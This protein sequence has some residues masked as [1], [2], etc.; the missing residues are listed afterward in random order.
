MRCAAQTYIEPVFDWTDVPNLHINKIEVTKDTTFVYCTYTAEAGS[1][2]NISQDTYLYDSV[3]KD[4]HPLLQ[5]LG[6]PISPQE[7]EFPYDSTYQVLFCFSSIG[8]ATKL[9]FIENLDEEAFNI[10]G[11]NLT[12]TFDTSYNEIDPE[13]NSEMSLSFDAAGD[14]INA[15]QY[16]EKE[17]KATAFIYGIKSKQFLMVVYDLCNMYEKYGYYEQAND[18]KKKIT[19]YIEALDDN[20]EKWHLL[21]CISSVFLQSKDLE[22][23]LEYRTMAV[24]IARRNWGNEHPKYATSLHELSINYYLIGNYAE[25][26]RLSTEAMEIRKNVLGAEHLNYV[27]SLN[28][29]AVYYAHLGKYEEAIRLGTEVL[30]ITRRG[31]CLEH[32]DYATALNNL[33]GYY[34]DFGNYEEAIRLGTEAM[35]ITK[36][37]LGPNHPDYAKA[38]YNLARFYLNIGNSEEAMRLGTET[39]EITKRVLGPDHPDYAK[40]LNTLA[41]CYSFVGNYFDAIRLGTEA[42]EITKKVLGTEHPE[43]ATLSLNLAGYYSDI[44]NYSKAIQLSTEALE[45]IKKVL[46]PDHPNYAT[47]LNNLASYYY[48]LRNYNTEAIRFGT[49]T[50]GIRKKVLDPDHPDYTQAIN[51]GMSKDFGW[52]KW[53]F[54]TIE[55]KYECIILTGYFVTS[56]NGPHEISNMDET[57]KILEKEYRIIYTSL[58]IDSLY[59]AQVHEWRAE[60]WYNHDPLITNE[61]ETSA[62][63]SQ[64]LLLKAI[65][66]HYFSKGDIANA[67]KFNPQNPY[68]H[69]ALGN[70]ETLLS[71]C[72]KAYEKSIDGLKSLIKDPVIITPGAYYN[73][74][75]DILYTS[76]L[77]TKIPYFAY[78]TNSVDLC[79]MAYNGALI[80]KNFRLLSDNRLRQYLKTTQNAISI[81][82]DTRIEKEKH[83]YKSMIQTKDLRSIDKGW[84][85]R[86]LQRGLIA[87][88]DSIGALNT[89][90][91]KW[92][93]VRSA[94]KENDIAVEFIEFPLWN[95][96]QSMYA[97]LTLRKESEHPKIIGLFEK[98]Q[99]MLISDTLYYQC[100]GMTDLVWKPLQSE[101]QGIKNIYF[102]PSGVLHKIGIEYLPGMENYNIFR[103]SS[104]RELVT[105]HEKRK[106]N[107]AVLYG[108]LEYDAK[109]DSTSTAKSLAL[110][111]ETFKMRGMGL[112][113]G[114]EY[115]ER[116][117]VEVV[118]IGEY[119]KDAKWTCLLDT[120]ALGTEE[121]FKSL[122]G[123][124]ISNLH[125]AT[126][127]FY[128][129]FDEVTNTN[130]D[131]L[132]EDTY[133]I[134]EEDKALKRSG[135]L[136]S[137]ANHILEGNS[138][139]Y[140]VEDGILTA[141]EIADVDLR[142]LDLVVLSACQTGLGDI[143]QGEGVFGLQRG[144][145]KAGA[146]TILMSLWEVDDKATQILMTQF[147]KNYLSGQSKHEA[148]LSAQK[149]L[150]EYNNGYYNKPRYWAAFI[151]LDG[152]E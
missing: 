102:S 55:F 145:K 72:K 92:T 65:E 1:R 37:V 74:E 130:Y 103:L 90:F 123:K 112:R 6:L 66:N 114:K 27:N 26:I 5:C 69:C 106:D 56:E 108:G 115:L 14:T 67:I 150:R 124:G 151:M 64:T 104:T 24:E 109:M 49:E 116:T 127:G 97:A 17:K 59:D 2:A 137:G 47:A 52:A 19:D 95:Q 152:L 28:D 16:K 9:D 53:F 57:I 48:H 111:D 105:K 75:F 11:I 101:L 85:I 125:I 62:L 12:S 35:E 36:K 70:T 143:S 32:P 29:I 100:G 50:T 30:K 77:T 147:Y 129:T 131:F 120:A 73:A 98:N 142:G 84:E 58:P 99:L 18:E 3:K 149:Y 63:F 13:Y 10:Y 94:L 21:S 22:K 132:Q 42:M 121:S 39:M 128:Y 43:Y 118:T 20:L 148:L 110:I 81:D 146:N 138:I 136:M 61:E 93:D 119:L 107:N 91:P 7:K 15:V 34:S 46:G 83:T 134:T 60:I 4:K 31:R 87:Y 40:A 54:E 45:I 51:I 141:K 8:N 23:S 78:K 80:T 25:A 41:S 76:A 140:D 88:L 38:L 89:F 33:A 117:K 133:N 96:N 71:L 135:L 126:H 139:P 86:Q 68:Y 144:F 79:K 44:G 122:S 113:G 82:Y